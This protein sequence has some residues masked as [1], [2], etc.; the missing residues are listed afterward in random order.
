MK[1]S[2]VILQQFYRNKFHF[3]FI[4]YNLLSIASIAIVFQQNQNSCDDK[5]NSLAL[6]NRLKLENPNNVKLCLEEISKFLEAD[7]IDISMDERKLRGKPWSSYHKIAKDPDAVIFPQ[8][9]E[10]VSK[11][12]QVCNKYR[13]PG[14]S[15]SFIY[16]FIYL[17]IA[18][19]SYTLWRWNEYRRS[20]FG[21]TRRHQFRF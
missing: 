8:T 2:F 10:E 6:K 11:I 15:C 5:S 12:L 4:R 21:S 7:Q 13:I 3:K 9:T 17:F 16:L 19:C 1:R 20:Y 14:I 18:L